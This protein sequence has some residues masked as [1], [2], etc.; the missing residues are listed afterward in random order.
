MAQPINPVKYLGWA[1][2]VNPFWKWKKDNSKE[3]QEA[4]CR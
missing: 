2:F 4:S 1:C 3:R